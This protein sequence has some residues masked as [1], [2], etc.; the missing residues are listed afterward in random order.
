MSATARGG[1]KVEPRHLHGQ[2]LSMM[3][4]NLPWS[5][6]LPA[7]VLVHAVTIRRFQQ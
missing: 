4:V 6:G 3:R 2:G 1:S 5:Q 7:H